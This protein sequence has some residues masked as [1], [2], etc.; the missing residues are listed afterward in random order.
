MSDEAYF[1]CM[2]IGFGL[3]CLFIGTFAIWIIHAIEG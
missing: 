1:W 3:F 2:C